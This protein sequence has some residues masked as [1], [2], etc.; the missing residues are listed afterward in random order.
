MTVRQDARTSQV[1]VVMRALSIST[2]EKIF[3]LSLPQTI[4]IA[5]EVPRVCVG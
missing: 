4:S 1:L 5:Y 3:T 2:R